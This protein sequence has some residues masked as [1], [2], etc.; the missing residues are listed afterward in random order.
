[1]VILLEFYDEENLE[2]KN[3]QE[4]IRVVMRFPFALA[5]VKCAILPLMEKDE[6]MSELAKEL[7]Q[8]LKKTRNIEYDA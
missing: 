6:K 7:T 8:K 1:M 3:G 4:D 2:S 5:P